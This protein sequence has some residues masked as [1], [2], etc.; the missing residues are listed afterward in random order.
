LPCILELLK[1]I[2]LS[3]I[4]AIIVDCHCYTNNNKEYGL[5]AHLW[6]AL[7][8]QVPIIGVAKNNFHKTEEVAFPVF[9]GES[10]SPLYV[11][12]IG[13]DVKKAI[14]NI[15]NMHGDFRFPTILKLVDSI[16]RELN[17]E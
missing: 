3:E 14:E 11:S 17:V 15:K 9:R 5:G 8:R 10:K 2:E 7:D 6:E 12:C 4:S 16:G 1:E 13:G